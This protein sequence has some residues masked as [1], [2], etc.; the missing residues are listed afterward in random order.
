M[1]QS[2]SVESQY[3]IPEVEVPEWMGKR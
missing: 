1:G 3:T 2:V